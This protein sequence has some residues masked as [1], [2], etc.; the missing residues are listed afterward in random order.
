MPSLRGRQGSSNPFTPL[1]FAVGLA[2]VKRELSPQALARC[3]AHKWQ[4]E[5]SPARLPRVR[6]GNQERDL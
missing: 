6:G 1:V 5:S 2:C 3:W 4:L